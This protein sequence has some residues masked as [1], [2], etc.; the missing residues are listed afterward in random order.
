MCKT[1]IRK[2]LKQ[3]SDIAVYSF[4]NQSVLSAIKA[5]QIKSK[6][7][8]IKQTRQT[9]FQSSTFFFFKNNTMGNWNSQNKATVTITLDQE[10]EEEIWM[11]RHWFQR[12]G[13]YLPQWPE[14][15]R[16]N[17]FP[18]ILLK[19]QPRCL[20]LKTVLNPQ[21][22]ENSVTAILQNSNQNNIVCFIGW[23]T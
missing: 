19:L 3:E 14:M 17:K 22:H 23:I 2:K 1:C 9:L 12:M 11:R 15:Q 21:A 8:G 4:C 10:Y 5:N 6:N 20:T 16:Q 18:T 13:K 7:S